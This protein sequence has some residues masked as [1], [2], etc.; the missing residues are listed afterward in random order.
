MSMIECPICGRLFTKSAISAHADRCLDETDVE[1]EDFVNDASFSL[2]S[3]R[4]RLQQEADVTLPLSPHFSSPIVRVNSEGTSDGVVPLTDHVSLSSTS[5]QSRPSTEARSETSQS[6][7]PNVQSLSVNASVVQTLKRPTKS[8]SLFGYFAPSQKSVIQ[9]NKSNLARDSVCDSSAL[10]SDVQLVNTQIKPAENIP[11]TVRC[12]AYSIKDSVTA[13]MTVS[14]SSTPVKQSAAVNHSLPMPTCIP[15]AEHMR[16]TTLADFV[17]QGH[18]VGSQ[19]PLRTL[20]E[21]ASLS[22]MI[23]WGPPGCGKVTLSSFMCVGVYVCGSGSSSS[24]S[25][26]IGGCCCCCCCGCLID[27]DI[28]RCSE[29]RMVNQ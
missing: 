4:P 18:I 17:G 11:D 13:A 6:S 28:T 25:S 29:S 19:R 8:T 21:S 23:L 12:S 5:V 1:D 20:L 15:L 24:S 14:K 10:P 26:S 7:A 16:P 27:H 3:K 22:S 9:Q 2:D